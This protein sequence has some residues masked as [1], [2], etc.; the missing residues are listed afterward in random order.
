MQ[1]N[2]YVINGAITE[3]QSVTD[4]ASRPI[5]KAP[6][7]LA[8]H[9]NDVVREAIAKKTVENKSFR[10]SVKSLSVLKGLMSC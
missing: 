3:V 6:I 8:K 5:V 4:M 7:K 10:G 9:R 2:S 1:N